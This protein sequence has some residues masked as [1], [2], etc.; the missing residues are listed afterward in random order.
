M[1]ENG[2]FDVKTHPRRSKRVLNQNR[3]LSV[4]TSYQ[5]LPY[6]FSYPLLDQH[7]C[8]VLGHWDDVATLKSVQTIVQSMTAIKNT[9]DQLKPNYLSSK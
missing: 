8:I 5:S 6:P 3:F 9:D 7:L 4:V 1:P 2:T